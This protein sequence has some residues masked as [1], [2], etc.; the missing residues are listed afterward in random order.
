MKAAA[1]C[2]RCNALIYLPDEN[3]AT[4]IDTE[5]SSRLYASVG[6]LVK[7]G[8]RLLDA[9][10]SRVQALQKVL[11]ADE[12][13]GAASPFDGED[14]RCILC[15]SAMGWPKPM[16]SPSVESKVNVAPSV[17]ETIAVRTES[18]SR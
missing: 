16:S 18:T 7:A 6:E 11:E 17:G 12:E 5:V 1:T 10:D 3:H 2:G 9:Q 13:S 14:C 4:F 8:L 15:T